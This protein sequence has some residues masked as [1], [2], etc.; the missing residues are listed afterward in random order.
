MKAGILVPRGVWVNFVARREGEYKGWPAVLAGAVAGDLAMLAN[1]SLLVA[2]L[3]C[4][5]PAMADITR[6]CSA[7]VGVY[8][9]DK[10]PNP[11]ALLGTIEARAGC[12]NK[13]HADDCRRLA[14]AQIDRC[15]TELWAGRNDNRLPSAC[16]S[17]ASGSSRPGARLQYEGILV[18]KESERFTARAA[19]TVCCHMR[20][21]TDR[22]MVSFDGRINGDQKCAA[23][24]IGKDSYQ[25]EFAMPQKYDMKCTE[26]RARGIC[27]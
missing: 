14:R 20:P 16:D 5:F 17:L 1:R 15:I 10:R 4:S 26:W 2:L 19:A 22:V 11:Y 13:L 18:I 7:T 6:G 24:R 3:A 9:M 23:T 21:T 27:G 25:D 8:V 12:K